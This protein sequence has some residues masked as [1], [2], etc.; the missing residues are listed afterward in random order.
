M[1]DHFRKVMTKK[2]DEQLIEI[3]VNYSR[4][5]ND[6]LRALVEQIETRAIKHD[7]LEELLNHLGRQEKIIEQKSQRFK[8]PDNLHPNI[9][10]AS[11]LMFLNIPIGIINMLIVNTI[12]DQILNGTKDRISLFITM[13]FVFILGYWLRMGSKTS[14]LVV[15]ILSI[16]GFI[17]SLPNLFTFFQF[18]VLPG[19]INL[20]QSLMGV[21]IIILL[22]Q[23]GSSNWYKKIKKEDNN[24]E[25]PLG[26][27]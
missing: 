17:L 13:V 14:R 9:K 4:Y 22:Y 6:A 11:T 2:S 1:S 18:G 27:I 10:L 21:L 16:I 15:S 24:T 19:A 20:I 23:K 8:I 7:S 5:S 12:D 25:H 26:F 3:L